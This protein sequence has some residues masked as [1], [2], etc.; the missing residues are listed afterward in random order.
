MN[1]TFE[2]SHDAI[3]RCS[4]EEHIPS[5][6]SINKQASTS[7]N[8]FLSVIGAIYGG[9]LSGA[10]GGEGKG[11]GEGGDGGG[12]GG[13]VHDHIFGG[14]YARRF[15]IVEVPPLPRMQLAC[16]FSAFRNMLIVETYDNV[17][18]LVISLLKLTAP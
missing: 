13:N 7:L 6:G 16:Q 9:G 17:F 12:A 4:L 10:G 11:G 1:V 15:P 5:T 2:T 18:H 14:P 3:T 8:K